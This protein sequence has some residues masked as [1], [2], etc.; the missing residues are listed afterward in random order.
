MSNQ[1]LGGFISMDHYDNVMDHTQRQFFAD[2]FAEWLKGVP[3]EHYVQLKVTTHTPLEGEIDVDMLVRAL[4]PEDD[5]E[6]M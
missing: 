1:D 6:G 5:E 3:R 2:E 4:Y